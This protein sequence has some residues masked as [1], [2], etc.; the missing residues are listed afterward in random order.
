MRNETQR[1][2]LETMDGVRVGWGGGG[3]Y[4]VGNETQRY[5]L[6]TMDGV[7][8]GWGVHSEERDAKICS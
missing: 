8:V 2:V 3:G 4:T 5:V 6:E 7:G 1:Y